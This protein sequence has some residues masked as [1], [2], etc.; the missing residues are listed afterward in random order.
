MI[1]HKILRAPA[2]APAPRNFTK[3]RNVMNLRE[4]QLHKISGTTLYV[5]NL[6]DEK[7]NKILGI[8][9]QKNNNFDNLGD[10]K[11]TYNSMLISGFGD[12]HTFN[13]RP[14]FNCNTL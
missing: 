3:S 8:L 12:I 6:V 1:A 4:K 14:K 13:P 11:F 9:R 5:A 10:C 7:A 2:P